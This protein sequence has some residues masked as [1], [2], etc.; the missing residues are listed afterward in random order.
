MKH[1]VHMYLAEH[2]HDMQHL[3][4]D[5]H[6]TSFVLSGGGGADLYT[7]KIEEAQRGPYASKVYGFSRLEV[8]PELLRLEHLDETGRVIHGFTKSPDGAVQILS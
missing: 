5:G 4:F 8:T 2:D 7:L 6:P 1:K 3:E